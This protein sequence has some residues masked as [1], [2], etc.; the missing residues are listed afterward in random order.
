MRRTLV[1]ILLLVSAGSVTWATRLALQTFT[2]TGSSKLTDSAHR[3]GS[4]WITRTEQ[5]WIV[6]DVVRAIDGIAR[7]TPD[8]T[9]KVAAVKPPDRATVLAAEYNVTADGISRR[10]LVARHLWSPETYAPLAEQLLGAASSPAADGDLGARTVLVDRRADVL[11]AENKRISAALQ[12]DMHSA[13]AHEAAALLIG[14]MALREASS[15]FG[16]VRP[17]L[18]RMTAHLAVARALRK[19]QTPGRD[20]L[21]ALAILTERAGLQRD[22]LQMVEDFD[23]QSTTDS[24]RAWSRAMRLR[25]TGDW[26]LYQPSQ[27]TTLTE[28][29]EYARALYQDRDE[30]AMVGYLDTFEAAQIPDWQRLVLSGGTAN[31]EVSGRFAATAATLELLEAGQA[32]NALHADATGDAE[33]LMASLNDRPAPSPVHR[34]AT[35][36]HVEVLDWGT[37]AAASQRQLCHSLVITLIHASNLRGDAAV[38]A[39]RRELERQFAGLTLFP[40]VDRWAADMHE[41]VSVTDYERITAAAWPIAE[42]TPELLTAAEWNYLLQ[43]PHGIARA[44]LFPLDRG[45]FE[46]S[47][48]A[49][50]AF[51]VEH[52]GLQPMCR[53]PAPLDDA[54]RWAHD[55]PYDPW[56]QWAFAWLPV[57]GKPSLGAVRKAMGPLLD[58]DVA[59][60]AM[61]YD[62]MDLSRD[63]QIDIAGQMCGLA[64]D[65]CVRLADLLLLDHRERD[66]AAAYERWIANAR[67]RVTVSNAVLWLVRYYRD[68][69]RLDDARATAAMAADTG[70]ARGLRT[71]GEQLEAEGRSD[72]AEQTYRSIVETYPDVTAPLGVFLLKRAIATND[73]GLQDQAFNLLRPVF[74]DGLQRPGPT[75]LDALP[76]DGAVFGT[77]G[78]RAASAGLKHD[79]I[80]VRVDGWRVRTAQQLIEAM[81]LSFDNAV[82]FT[83]WRGHKYEEIHAKVPQRLLGVNF[84]TYVPP[85]STK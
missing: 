78:R 29:I 85:V 23:R 59:A 34:D 31:V 9:V 73:A 18:S 58:Y 75:E 26:R 4:D 55:R 61:I 19:E 2:F 10:V 39:M 80:I 72:E 7:N 45:W 22:A 83:V 84:R 32:W 79:D 14:T 33:R 8:V 70:S 53:W 56:T 40:V 17:A 60:L 42:R 1:V 69:G 50:T 43:P 47:S 62:Y 12:A 5:E 38:D 20:G 77:F 41:E 48:P 65:R 67:D 63:Q 30:N 15:I 64:A 51:D 35:G 71:L 76:A 16:D 21:L 28:R 81:R 36:T 13:P 52:R 3:L 37:W 82:T 49:G 74:P 57:T 27:L 66:A 25:I 44:A 54:A 46:S 68:T 11:L 24:D 6:T